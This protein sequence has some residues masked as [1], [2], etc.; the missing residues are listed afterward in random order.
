MRIKNIFDR[1]WLIKQI[2]YEKGP[3]EAI[4][5]IGYASASTTSELQPIC[6]PAHTTNSDVKNCKSEVLSIEMQEMVQREFDVCSHAAAKYPN[7]YNAWSHRIW[8]VQNVCHCSEEV[9][10]KTHYKT[11]DITLT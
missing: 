5:T 11:T 3:K 2:Q 10:L 8:L 7:N 9:R 1:K 4:E 6:S